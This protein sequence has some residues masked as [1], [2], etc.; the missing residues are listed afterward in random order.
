[1]LLLFLHYVWLDALQAFGLLYFL[2]YLSVRR[3]S[4]PQRLLAL[5]FYTLLLSGGPR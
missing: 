3:I 5:H 1:M 4:L 2:L